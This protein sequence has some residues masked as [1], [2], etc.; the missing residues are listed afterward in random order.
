MINHQLH[1]V[2]DSYTLGSIKDSERSR[3][4]LVEPLNFYG[5][6]LNSKMSIQTD[7]FWAANFN[8]QD[9]QKG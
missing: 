9:L 2:C 5:I 8:K 7:Q 1:V 3:L 4:N 6:K